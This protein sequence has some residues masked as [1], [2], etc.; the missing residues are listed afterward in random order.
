[1]TQ[2]F[3]R[4]DAGIVRAAPVASPSGSRAALHWLPLVFGTALVGVGAFALV[5]VVRDVFGAAQIHAITAATATTEVPT[6]TPDPVFRKQAE[7][8]VMALERELTPEPTNTPEPTRSP[9]ATVF[10]SPSCEQL[11]RAGAGGE[12]I[13][14][15][16]TV[17][18]MPALP[19]CETPVVYERCI[20]FLAPTSAPVR[21]PTGGGVMTE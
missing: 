8:S 10:V 11:M 4:D 21:P 17:A 3:H 6:A 18:A 15:T 2:W 7:L 9:T 13:W 5:M 16:A 19:V 14:S 1:M 12:C 20:L